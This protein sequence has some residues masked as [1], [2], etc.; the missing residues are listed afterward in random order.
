MK[1]G[2]GWSDHGCPSV[3][4]PGERVPQLE[5]GHLGRSGVTVVA[6]AAASVAA[7]VSTV[8]AASAA[9]TV[10]AAADRVGRKSSVVALPILA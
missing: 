7:T 9:A 1:T 8:V 3:E 10:A 2:L 4:F 5:N 6:V